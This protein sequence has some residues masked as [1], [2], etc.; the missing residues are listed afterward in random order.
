MKDT[1]ICIHVH[2][3]GEN[4]LTKRIMNLEQVEERIFHGDICFTYVQVLDGDLKRE[5]LIYGNEP[6]DVEEALSYIL[7][8]KVDES[9]IVGKI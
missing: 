3:D 1:Y 9:C 8:A 7:S 2:E 6:E 4:E 5:L